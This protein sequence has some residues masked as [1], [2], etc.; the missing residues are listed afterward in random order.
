MKKLLLAGLLG[1]A[2][3]SAAPEEKAAAPADSLHTAVEAYL[4]KTADDP[5]SYQPAGWG[6]PNPWQQ[7]DV[8]ALAARD[9][10]E[11]AKISY[12]YTVKAARYT[13][14]G[15]R[16]LFADNAAATKRF[17]LLEDS[18]LRSK[19]TTNLGVVVTHTYRAKNKMGA[20]VL[21]SAQFIVYKNGKVQKL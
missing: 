14:P 10:A 21:D 1:L 15:G 3:C 11:K 8:D 20:L 2:A 5:A 7:R 6:R 16:K 17:Q 9:A 12:E 18:L 13:T 4:K 19:D